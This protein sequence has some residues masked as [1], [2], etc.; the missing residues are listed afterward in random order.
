[1]FADLHTI[2]SGMI[3]GIIFLQTAVIA[4]SVFKNL[5]QSHTRN[6]FILG[7]YLLKNQIL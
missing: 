1:M 2:I 5:D 4:P 7:F 6:Q 3:C